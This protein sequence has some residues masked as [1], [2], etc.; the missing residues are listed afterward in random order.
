MALID[1]LEGVVR[2]QKVSIEALEGRVERVRELLGGDVSLEGPSSAGAGVGT[3]GGN[4]AGTG[5][6]AAEAAAAA[7]AAAARKKH[8]EEMARC[9]W[10]P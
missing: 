2:E 5:S 9:M 4:T 1:R 8:E 6:A 7:A 10:I 3:A